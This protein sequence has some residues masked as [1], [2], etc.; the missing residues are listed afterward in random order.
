V[1]D[2]AVLL[3]EVFSLFGIS[4]F[5]GEGGRCG[6]SHN[7]ETGDN[8]ADAFHVFLHLVF[9]APVEQLVSRVHTVC[10]TL[11]PLPFFAL[12]EMSGGAFGA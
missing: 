7:G 1:A 11:G 9:A 4:T 10:P 8:F 12:S 2:L 3:V 6:K 5:G